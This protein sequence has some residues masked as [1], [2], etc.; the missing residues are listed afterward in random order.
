MNKKG[1]KAKVGSGISFK[2]NDKKLKELI[3]YVAK[4]SESD[5]S[6]GRTKLNKI[7][8]FS[9]F[10]TYGQTGQPITGHIYHKIENGPGLKSF[11][12]IT[13]E[14][15]EDGDCSEQTR[16][17]FGYVQKRVIALREP[18]LGMF[19]GAEIGIVEEV[20][21][22]FEA[23]N[24]SATSQAS[25]TFIGWRAFEIGDEIPYSTAFVSCRELSE[26]EKQYALE[27]VSTCAR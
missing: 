7:L 2:P 8:F 5:P 23:L 12:L 22:H 20:L 27:L 4:R 18:E 14:M 19:S 13:D 6:F 16:D 26:R 25:H 11:H 3:L 9:D 1:R 10:I 15:K 17:H 24:A 21:K